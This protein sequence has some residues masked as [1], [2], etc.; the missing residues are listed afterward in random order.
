MDEEKKE[1]KAACLVANGVLGRLDAVAEKLAAKITGGGSLSRS[2]AMRAVLMRGLLS[3]E[4]ELGLTK[5]K[6]AS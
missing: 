5:K 6:K 4:D 2:Q 3:Y 1:E